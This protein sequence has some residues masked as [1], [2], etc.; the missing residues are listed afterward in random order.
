MGS[1]KSERDATAACFLWTDDSSWE[2][3]TS[4]EAASFKKSSYRIPTYTLNL[5]DDRKNGAAR[6][7]NKKKIDR[8]LFYL[9]QLTQD[10]TSK[11]REH[12]VLPLWT[13]RKGVVSRR[14][15]WNIEEVK[16]GFWGI[17]R[18]PPRLVPSIF[19]SSQFTSIPVRKNIIWATAIAASWHMKTWIPVK[20]IIFT[21]RSP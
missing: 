19:I 18:E 17:L 13:S 12:V 8:K 21:S 5:N 14:S 1:G 6:R 7:T 9:A 4:L 11:Q 3:S 2:I 20:K 15:T 10:Y 16:D